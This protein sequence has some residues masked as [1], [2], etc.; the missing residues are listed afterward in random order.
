M[1]NLHHST[2]KT[3]AIGYAIREQN[4]PILDDLNINAAEITFERADDPLRIDKF[5]RDN[6]FDHV[7]VHALKLSPAGAQPPARKYLE[8]IRD[9]A[10]E[11]GAQSVS[12]HLG[13]TRDSDKGAELGH[14][15]PPPWT[16]QAL[17]ATCHNVDHIQKFF[18]D[19]RFYIETIAYLF[20]FEGTMREADFVASLLKR[21]GCGWLLDVTNVY[22]N[23]VNFGF[24]PYEFIAT[25]MPHAASVQM[26]LAGGFYDEKSEMY[27]DSHSEPIPDPVW[28]LYRFSLWQGI[29]KVEA[30]FIERDQNFPDESGWR[31]EVRRV[32]EIAEQV[33]VPA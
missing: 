2:L 1:T 18:G 31:S 29:G 21:T 23:S 20:E 6:D 32:R 7:S 12:D 4:R 19:T 10:I 17:D 33:E 8:A 14:F 11:N 9:V 27:I 15:A 30:V 16:Q 28:D 22:A 5:I 3:P 13:F 25:V 24:D 26:H